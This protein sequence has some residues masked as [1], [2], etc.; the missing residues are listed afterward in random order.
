MIQGK[1]GL[2]KMKTIFVATHNAHKI[3]EIGEKIKLRHKGTKS[4][5]RGQN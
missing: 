4:L 1:A 2:G 3:R 5:F